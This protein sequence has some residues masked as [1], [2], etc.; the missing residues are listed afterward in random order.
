MREGRHP[1]LAGYFGTSPS[2]STPW[3]LLLPP[4]V[5][6]GMPMIRAWLEPYSFTVSVTG[7]L[8]FSLAGS[9]TEMPRVSS[10]VPPPISSTGYGVLSTISFKIGVAVET[11]LGFRYQG[12]CRRGGGAAIL[13]RIAKSGYS[14][15]ALVA[16]MYRRPDRAFPPAA[17]GL[18]QKV[19]SF[20]GHVIWENSYAQ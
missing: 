2:Q 4:A 10:A 3:W 8:G 6:L 15:R 20:M 11:G 14:F 5:L 16:P 19:V 1:P 12:Y 18:N 13:T 9:W 17:S 7:A